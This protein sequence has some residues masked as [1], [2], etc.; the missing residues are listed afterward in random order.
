[1]KLYFEGENEEHCYSLDAVKAHMEI[2]GWEEMELY[3]AK[4]Q[5]A[6]G[7]FYCRY[8]FNIGERD[9]GECGKH[10]DG[11]TP[12]NGKSGCCTHYSLKLYE[13]GKK[14]VLVRNRNKFKLKTTKT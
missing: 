12:R 6:D 11:Y 7:F 2:Y 13:P 5:E 4:R 10:C 8:Y 9:N 3:E 14:V 1:M